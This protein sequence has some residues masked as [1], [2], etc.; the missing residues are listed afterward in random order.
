M[1][2]LVALSVLAVFAACGTDPSGDDDIGDDDTP[3][4]TDGVSTL[5]GAADPGYVDGPR[6]DARFANPVNVA[7]GPD[8]QL[9]VADFDNGK[10]RVVDPEDGQTATVIAQ[11]GFKR[12]FALAFAPDGTLYVTT[13]ANSSGGPQGPMTG[14]IWAVDVGAKSATIVAENVGRPRGIA[15]LP[16]GRLAI[17]DYQHHVIELVNPGSGSVSTLAGAWDAPGM[18]DGAAARFSVPYGL[19]VF[20][21]KLV[22]ADQDNNRLRLVGLDGS[23][24]TLCGESGGFADG[25]MAS[26]RFARPQGVAVDGRGT[27]YVTDADNYRVRRISGDTVETIAGSGEPGYLDSDDRLEAQLYGLEGLSVSPDGEMV[28]VADGGRGED[29][30]YNR[31]R[32]I[33]L[34]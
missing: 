13:D 25:A 15:V 6:G 23:V 26:A 7:L 8:G 19:A 24:Q 14:T 34:P 3:P 12:P 11:E 21:G 28:Y 27:I 4:F 30:P 16:D 22:V 33:K 20:D 32:S 2:K 10:I 18:V 17:S 9:Y 29:V 31:V 1:K 5:S